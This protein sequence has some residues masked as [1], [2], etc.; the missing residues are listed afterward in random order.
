[1]PA[2]THL[3]PA[4]LLL[5]AIACLPLSAQAASPDD[6]A[7]NQQGREIALRISEE[8]DSDLSAAERNRIAAIAEAVCVEYSAQAAA[9]PAPAP[10]MPVV[11]RPERPQ[12]EAAAV[13]APPQAPAAGNT[14]EADDEEEGGLF[15]IRII[16]PEDRV[17]RPGLKRR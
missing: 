11:S 17:Q 9:M 2:Q 10:A 8:V 3:L 15:D 6:R 7:C 4:S 14:A 12:A 5:G 1:M 16:D 13:A